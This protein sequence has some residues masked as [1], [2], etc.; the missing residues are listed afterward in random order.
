MIKR[1]KDSKGVV[2]REGEYQ[3]KEN[4]YEFRWTDKIGKRRSIYASDLTN[5]RNKQKEILRNTLDGIDENG[6]NLTINDVYK[7]WKKIKRGIKD[8]TFRNYVYMYEQYVYSE[9]GKLKI[10]QVKRTDVRSF[11]NNLKEKQG[12]KVSTID[13]IHTVLLQVFDLALE[14]DYMRYNPATKALKELRMSCS[15]ADKRKALTI[16]E[17]KVFEEYL[18]TSTKYKRWLPIYTVMLYTGMRVGEVTA[19]NWN[20]I[21]VEKGVITVSKTLVYYSKGKGKGNKYAVNTPKTKAGVRKIPMLEKVKEAFLLEKELQEA[22]EIKCKDSIDGYSD[23]IFLNRFGE[24][25]NYGTL[26]KALARIIRDLN[27]EVLDNAKDSEEVITVP[28][29]SNHIFRHTFSTRMFEAGVNIKIMQS[30]L[31]HSDIGTTMDVYTDVTNDYLSEAVKN[32]DLKFK[33][34]NYHTST[35]DLPQVRR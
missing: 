32:M 28:K 24:V 12:L 5:L 14:E 33:E 10:V 35:T 2:L 7:K 18:A 20:D 15:N 13:C 6:L 22:F 16:Q 4:L 29:I 26:N 27:F 9:F 25:H 11:Y 1:R 8:N 3:K 17:Q 23:F 30:I 31:G 19:L 21:D 34:M